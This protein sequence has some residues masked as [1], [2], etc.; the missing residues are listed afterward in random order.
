V[1]YDPTLAPFTALNWLRCEIGDTDASYQMFTDN[2]LNALLTKMASDG[3]KCAGMAFVVLSL[4]VIR[5]ANM[6]NACSNVT[7]LGLAE[8]YAERAVTALGG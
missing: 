6:L 3:W 1:A 4:D 2:E 8:T 7:L 5:L